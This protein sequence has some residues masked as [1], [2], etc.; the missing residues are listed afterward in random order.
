VAQNGEVDAVNHGGGAWLSIICDHGVD[1]NAQ[2]LVGGALRIRRASSV[3]V[4]SGC[5]EL[6]GGPTHSELKSLVA[7]DG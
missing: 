2:L 3:A 6:G 1:N 5:N 7:I 4:G